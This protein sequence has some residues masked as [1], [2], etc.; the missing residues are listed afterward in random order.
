MLV[1]GHF[2]FHNSNESNFIRSQNVFK[3]HGLA[4]DR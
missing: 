2:S 3:A 1:S 4:T